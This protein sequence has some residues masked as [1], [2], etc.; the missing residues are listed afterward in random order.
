MY[1]SSLILA[2]K[3]GD[4]TRRPLGAANLLCNK[5]VAGV[6]R[7]VWGVAEA[8]IS[9]LAHKTVILGVW[10]T[11]HAVRCVRVPC[12]SVDVVDAH[13]QQHRLRPLTK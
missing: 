5:L 6:F 7:D 1:A 2:M 11:R 3:W 10:A 8:A 4:A 13:L 9:V 12:V